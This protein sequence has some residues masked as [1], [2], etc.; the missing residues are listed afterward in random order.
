[1]K[2]DVLYAIYCFLII[3]I[4]IHFKNP[5]SAAVAT[6][7][8]AERERPI[9]NMRTCIAPKRSAIKRQYNTVYNQLPILTV[10]S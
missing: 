4:L 6:V 3:S 1:M 5:F 10:Q 8:C 7:M 2:R 9:Q